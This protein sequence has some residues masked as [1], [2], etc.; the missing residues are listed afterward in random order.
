MTHEERTPEAI[1]HH[2]LVERELADRLRNAP[3]QQ[4]PALYRETYDELFRRVADHPQ[5]TRAANP[6]TRREAVERQARYVTRYLDST[7][8]FLEIGGG[9]CAL[10]RRL[11]SSVERV[12]V[13]EVSPEIVPDDLPPNVEVRMTDGTAIPAEHIDVAFSNQLMEHLHPDDA[14]RQLHNIYAALRP[15]GRYVCVTPNRL[16]GPHDVSMYFDHVATGF[17]LREYT[18]RELAALMREAGFRRVVG[19]LPHGSGA[20]EYPV[21]TIG[22]IEQALRFVPPRLRR[23]LPE[24]VKRLLNLRLVAMK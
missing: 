8:H 9:D 20:T 4:R 3:S 6:D 12:T 18:N 19:A 14:E 22:L 10:S 23:K 11:S 15:G 13:A 21:W 24:A 2:Y 17:H 7:S 5:H 1:R 16:V